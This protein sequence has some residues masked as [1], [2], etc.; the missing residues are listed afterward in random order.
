MQGFSSGLGSGA[1]AGSY[2]SRML[3][4]VG[5]I[6]RF[7]YDMRPCLECNF[8]GFRHV[9][10]P[11]SALQCKLGSSGLQAFR[12]YGPKFM[13]ASD[14]KSKLQGCKTEILDPAARGFRV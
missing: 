8:L 11:T 6:T 5:V 9:S 10:V 13:G 3:G 1:K 7:V 4:F 14:C 2:A 12:V